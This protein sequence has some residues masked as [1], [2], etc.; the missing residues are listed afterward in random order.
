MK[1]HTV[2]TVVLSTLLLA[3]APVL[4]Q[5]GINPA[6]QWS[7]SVPGA[8]FLYYDALD[9]VIWAAIPAQGAMVAISP[10]THQ[11]VASQPMGLQ[12]ADCDVD[13][14]FNNLWCIGADQVGTANTI[15]VFNMAD[16][17]LCGFGCGS[18]Q[19]W[20]GWLPT[21]GAPYSISVDATDRAA[22]I[23]SGGALYEWS[24]KVGHS[25][26]L[27]T[28]TPPD[29]FAAQN[30]TYMPLCGTETGFMMTAY[31]INGNGA[32]QTDW[33]YYDLA[34]AQTCMVGMPQK[35]W[36]GASEF[37]GVNNFFFPGAGT[38]PVSVAGYYVQIVSNAP[39]AGP[40][41]GT[42][43]MLV[44][45]WGRGPVGAAYAQYNVDAT[46]NKANPPF[47]P[48]AVIGQAYDK[49][50]AIY[51]AVTETELQAPPY[52]LGPVQVIITTAVPF[53]W[54]YPGGV[55]PGI[56]VAN[57]VYATVDGANRIAYT[58][59]TDGLITAISY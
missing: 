18:G 12:V 54:P 25:A 4:A 20:V 38:K 37:T 24:I 11:V 16:T 30:A 6:I 15:T 10:A 49:T 39:E 31:G 58:S 34:P 41:I 47:G 28:F 53:H 40:M 14:A 19:I 52:G 33:W 56:T 45:G 57:A 7:A 36:L 51:I 32:P 48:A 17:L 22:F 59:G 35:P 13:V 1:T 5:A 9:S 23:V 44:P 8:T 46:E 3:V 50:H 21:S 43:W 2:V 55:E 26:I 42:S 29:G 27:R